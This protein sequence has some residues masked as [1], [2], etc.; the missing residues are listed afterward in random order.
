MEMFFFWCMC[1]LVSGV[2]A[3][4]YNRNVGAWVVLGLLIGF[5]APVLL[6]AAGE[7]KEG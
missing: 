4:R 5:F 2:L 6:L 3:N 7:N 1:S